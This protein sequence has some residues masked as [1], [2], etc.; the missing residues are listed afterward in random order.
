MAARARPARFP[1]NGAWP[2]VLRADMA[3]AFL[4]YPDTAALTRAITRGEA[5]AP[6]S[7]R[8]AGARREPI[9]AREAVMRFVARMNDVAN[10][11][12]ETE[13]DIRSLL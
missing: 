4:D 5:P 8:R 9:W 1:P 10:D 3:A 2:A 12:A 13:D 7:L 11:N 6:T